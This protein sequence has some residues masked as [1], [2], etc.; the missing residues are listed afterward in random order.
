M[1]IPFGTS[2]PNYNNIKIFPSPFMIPA[3]KPMVVSGLLKNSSMKI[4]TLD[5]HVVRN[6][7]S[8]GISIDGDQLL[9]DGKDSNGIYVT[10]GVYLLAIYGVSNNTFSKVTV[11]RE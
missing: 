5:G 1:R 8:Q 6:I 2:V 11:I 3:N 9:W 4:M 10:S 7:P